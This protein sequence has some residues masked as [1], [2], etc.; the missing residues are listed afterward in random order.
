MKRKLVCFHEA[1]YM[2]NVFGRFPRKYDA[3]GPG[4]DLIG[5]FFRPKFKDTIIRGVGFS[6]PILAPAD[7]DLIHRDEPEFI[8]DI[9]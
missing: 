8:Y 4:G 3:Y 7:V 5:I 1:K 9:L 2:E 6:E